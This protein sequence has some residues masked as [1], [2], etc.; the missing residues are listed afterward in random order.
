MVFYLPFQRKT[1]RQKNGKSAK[2]F[3]VLYMVVPNAM[4]RS[5]FNHFFNLCSE[6]F[7]S[8][9]KSFA[10]F[11]TYKGT[12]RNA[13]TELFGCVCDILRNVFL[14]LRFNI[15]LLEQA[16][17]FIEFAK[18]PLNNFFNRSRRLVGTLRVIRHLRFENFHLLGNHRRRHAFAG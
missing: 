18:L 15:F 13:A 7:F 14:V 10:L 17:C 2:A 4:I 8:L 3:P 16:I 6:I 1:S 5:A 11:I 9:L 12:N